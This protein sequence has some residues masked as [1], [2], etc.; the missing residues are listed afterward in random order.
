MEIHNGIPFTDSDEIARNIKKGQVVVIPRPGVPDPEQM[1]AEMDAGGSM[2]AFVT[3]W[4]E[5]GCVVA[6]GPDW[7]KV[8]MCIML[9]NRPTITN[10]YRRIGYDDIGGIM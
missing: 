2:E 10:E 6:W 7:V 3:R 5:W 4:F 9:N 8:R 1:S